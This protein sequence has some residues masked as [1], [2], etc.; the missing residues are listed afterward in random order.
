[1]S[2]TISQGNLFT[3][4]P[5]ATE[6]VAFVFD[7]PEGVAIASEEVEEAL[8]RGSEEDTGITVGTPLESE[9][10]VTVPITSATEGQMWSLTCT[11]TT[12]E[13]PAQVFVSM[14]YVNCETP[15]G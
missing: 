4:P 3:I 9:G 1:M 13:V 15:R 8:I 5:G 2:L 12:T 14:A 11:V 10:T 6:A 7:L